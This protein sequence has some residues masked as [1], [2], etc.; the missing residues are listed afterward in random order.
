MKR[1]ANSVKEEEN[2]CGERENSLLTVGVRL[3][4]RCKVATFVSC[5]DVGL[6]Q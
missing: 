3:D 1:A 5:Q 6:F 2:V 4:G